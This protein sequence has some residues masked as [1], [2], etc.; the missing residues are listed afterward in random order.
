MIIHTRMRAF[1]RERRKTS[2]QCEDNPPSSLLFRL[3]VMMC[4]SIE[5]RAFADAIT[6][7]KKVHCGHEDVAVNID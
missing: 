2:L 7:V 1:S 4:L 6:V 3:I 5:R